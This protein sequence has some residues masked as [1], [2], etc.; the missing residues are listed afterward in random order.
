MALKI[1]WSRILAVAILYIIVGEIV[2]TLGAMADMNYYMDS[3]YFSVWSKIMM[4]TA[5]PPAAEFYY[6]SIASQLVTGFLFAFVYAVIKGAVP[7]KGWKNKGL[8]YGFLVFLVAGIPTT[9]T[10]ILLINL[11]IGL[12]LSWMLQSL[13]VYLVMGL[14][15]AKLIK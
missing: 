12:L 7:G 4:P 10:F 14:V 11:P 1:P 2:M 13:V 3:N 9:L 8:M 15:G 6:I 5:G